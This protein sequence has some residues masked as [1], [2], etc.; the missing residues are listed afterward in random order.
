MHS[1]ISIGNNSNIRFDSILLRIISFYDHMEILV[2]ALRPA[3]IKHIAA[4]GDSL[5]VCF[6]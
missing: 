3:D 4:M 5:T 1:I 6:F 2:H